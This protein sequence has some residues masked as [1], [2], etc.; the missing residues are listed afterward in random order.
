[1]SGICGL[2]RLDGR[3]LERETMECM[4]DI[5]AH[6]GPDGRGVWHRDRLG[7]GHRM[8]WTTPESL[9]ERLPRMNV[10][11]DLAITAE[12]RIDNRE[13]LFESLGIPRGPEAVSDSALILAGYERWGERC[14]EHRVLSAGLHDLT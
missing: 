7:L 12:A 4:T 9:S 14:P 10:R 13:E 3:P 5:L 6:R 1:M 8:L 2:W 11:E